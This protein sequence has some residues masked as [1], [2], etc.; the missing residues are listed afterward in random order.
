MNDDLTAH[1]K[2]PEQKK[3]LTIY[4]LF[5][6]AL[7]GSFLPSLIFASAAFI[8]FFVVLIAA[9]IMRGGADEDSLTQNHMT[10]LIR[11]IWIGSLIMTVTTL[12]GSVY[13]YASVDNA[14]LMPCLERFVDSSTLMQAQSMSGLKQL[15]GSCFDSYI[16]VNLMVF[17]IG[18]IICA[19]APVAYFSYRLFTGTKATLNNAKITNVKRWL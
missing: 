14:P 10:Y 6:A 2:A 19:G 17:I 7:L 3:T 1:T 11:T 18:G 9:Y 13:L 5:I 12:V 15:F 8:L 16:K 4:G